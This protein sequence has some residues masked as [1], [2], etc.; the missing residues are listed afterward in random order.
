MKR[1]NIVQTAQ[2][3]KCIAQSGGLLRSSQRSVERKAKKKAKEASEVAKAAPKKEQE[4]DEAEEPVQQSSEN[5][6]QGETRAK[7]RLATNTWKD[8]I[9]AMGGN[10]IVAGILGLFAVTQASLLYAI[11]QLGRWAERPFEEQSSPSFLWRIGMAGVAVLV[12]SVIRSTWAFALTLKASRNL[13]DKMTLA[14]LRSKIEFFDTN[15]LGR[16][17]NRFSADVGSNDD[18]LPASLND[19]FAIGFVVLGA[20]VTAASVMPFLLIAFPPIL[21]Y[22]ARARR[23]FIAASRE[24]KRLEGLARSPIYAMMAE[25]VNGIA[26]IRANGS[27][28]FFMKRFAMVQNAHSR[29]FFSFIACTRWLNFRLESIQIIL[30]STACLMAVLFHSNSWFN[31]DPA[32]LGLA[33]TLLLQLSGLLQWAVRQSSEVINHMVAVE[34]VA[35]YGK[36]EPEAP[37]E[38][39][40]DNRLDAQ[41]PQ[42]GAVAVSDLAVRYRDSLPSALS[43]LT[44]DVIGG[45]RIGVVGRTGS[46]KV[47]WRLLELSIF[48]C[49]AYPS[50]FS[51]STSV[52]FYPSLVSLVGA[53]RG[54]D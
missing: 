21:W 40:N 22:F 45:H 12:L 18:Q 53:R 7:G 48:N 36:L 15:P 25:S 24:L 47:R 3:E 1:G 37:L 6:S 52:N 35:A 54:I 19:T 17:L 8:Y 46:G 33:L 41:W 49:V 39:E 14:V 28:H 34:R 20:V 13:H 51:F 11:A 42:D 29:A 43:G 9:G 23:M 16:I 26:C 30:L 2:Y 38:T 44:F 50:I 31:V 5:Q 4:E 27:V 32:I 10:W